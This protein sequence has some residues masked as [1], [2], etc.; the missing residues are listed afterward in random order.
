[1]SFWEHTWGAGLLLAGIAILLRA[2]SRGKVVVPMAAVSGLLMAGGVMMRRDTMIPAVIFLALL[3]VLLRRRDAFVAAAMAFAVLVVPIGL[4]L[5][6]HPEPLAVGLTHAS[7]GRAGLGVRS[8]LTALDKI[9]FLVS[10]GWATGLA[11]VLC[12]A[13]L[14]ARR[15]SASLVTPIVA[16]GSMIVGLA[17]ALT[18]LV[19]A[20]T[21]SDEN[22]LAFCPLALWGLLLPLT[23]PASTGHSGARNEG[24][25]VWR[26]RPREPV[27]VLV[28]ALAI[29]GA[30]AVSVTASDSGGTQWGPRYLL[31]AFPLLALLALK[32]RERMVA[33]ASG[34]ARLRLINYS[35]V[36]ILG[37]SVLLQCLGLCGLQDKQDLVARVSAAVATTHASVVVSAYPVIDELAP[38]YE[39]SRYLY[40]PTQSDLDQLMRQLRSTGTR[41]SRHALRPAPPVPVEWILRLVS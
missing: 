5:L 9:E 20:H 33:A 4:I 21:L 22:I 18:A 32:A 27:A 13:G 15:L 38:T 34:P 39:T 40:A 16:V 14:A 28:W 41:R 17:L 19:G 31:F 26:W 25:G 2:V 1:M 36:G 23:S 11:A 35:F 24:W 37:L 30:V 12:G 7:P 10:G 6:L 3:P 8:G 29:V